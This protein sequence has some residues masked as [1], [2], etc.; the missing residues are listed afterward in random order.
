L[1]LNSFKTIQIAYSKT[2]NNACEL[3]ID[4]NLLLE[5]ER[6]ARAYLLSHI[7]IE[8][9]A[10]CIMLSS[11]IMK[12]KIKSLDVKKLMKRQRNHHSKIELAYSLLEILKNYSSPLSREDRVSIATTE[13]PKYIIGDNEVQKL[14]D[15][16][17]SSLYTDQ[18]GNVTKEP[19]E[20]ITFKEAESLLNSA[21]L[22][23][24]YIKL[25]NWHEGE[26]LINLAKR[27]D[28]Q[29]LTKIK[30]DHFGDKKKI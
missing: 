10:R 3:L 15:L 24:E 30:V 29:A 4:A 6:Y 1:S 7:A 26:N 25:N 22:L 12:T 13:L 18:Y 5:N 11:A 23:K 27:L 20:V 14:D 19:N 16:K 17:N 9:L 21:M 8:E 2:F 28:D